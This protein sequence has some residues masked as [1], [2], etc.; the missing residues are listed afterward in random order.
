M[1]AAFTGPKRNPFFTFSWHNR[2]LAANVNL[3]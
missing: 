1:V 2:Q 3:A